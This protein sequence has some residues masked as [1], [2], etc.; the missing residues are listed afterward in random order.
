[1]LRNHCRFTLGLENSPANHIAF[2]CNDYTQGT[3][4]AA[5][6]APDAPSPLLH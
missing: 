3:E 2:H 4:F 6:S 5:S 1:M